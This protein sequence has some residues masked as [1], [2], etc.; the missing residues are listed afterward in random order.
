MPQRGVGAVWGRFRASDK[1]A[2]SAAFVPHT[3]FRV[4]ISFVM[5]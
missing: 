1:D 4:N 3:F 5:D 2:I